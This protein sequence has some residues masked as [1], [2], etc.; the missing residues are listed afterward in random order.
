[1]LGGAPFLRPGTPVLDLSRF[2]SDPAEGAVFTSPYGFPPSS[3]GVTDAQIAAWESKHGVVLPA[4]FR[5][6]LKDRNGGQ[7]RDG[8][9]LYVHSLDQIA[10]VDRDLLRYADFDSD[11]DLDPELLFAFAANDLGGLYLLDYSARGRRGEPA[12][13]VYY[14]DPGDVSNAADS[15]EEFFGAMLATEEA[16][17]VDWSEADRLVVLARETI[18]ISTTHGRGGTFEQVLGRTAEGFVLLT[19][20]CSPMGEMLART[21]LPAPLDPAWASITDFRPAPVGTRYLHLQPREIDG[22]VSVVSRRSEDG[23]WKNEESRGVPI[24]ARFESTNSQRLNELRR[25][26][27]GDEAAREAAARD[28]AQAQWTGRMESLPDEQRRAGMMA[29]FLKMQSE[30]AGAFGPA[31]D[32][33]DLPPDLAA[34][35]ENIARKLAEVTAKAREQLAA[36]PL[37]PATA[38]MLEQV[39]RS[40]ASPPLPNS[41]AGRPP[42]G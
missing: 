9:E 35:A 21:F 20:E 34:A 23:A 37:D 33:A 29:M 16:P 4:L 17:A 13:S 11:G 41:E 8:D 25:T 14:G 36:H 10:P 42:Q 39:V 28:A 27:F 1:M 19:R 5:G 2:W 30:M 31:P 18:D 24:Y 15:L 40:Q 38:A 22:V 26:V 32:P 12:V 6:V 7:V 3:P